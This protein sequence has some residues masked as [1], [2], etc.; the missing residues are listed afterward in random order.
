MVSELGMELFACQVAFVIVSLTGPLSGV[1]FGGWLVDKMGGYK[2]ESGHAMILTLRTCNMFGV[3]A[4]IAAIP[5]AFVLNYV[6]AMVS[7]WFVLFF[8]AALL[9]ALNGVMISCVPEEARSIAS[10]F[11]MF[12]YSIFGYALA[13]ILCGIIAQ[14][15]TLK[16]GWQVVLLVSFVA[17]IS[18]LGS[19][20]F[21]LREYNNN[22]HKELELT[23]GDDLEDGSEGDDRRSPSSSFDS[24]AKHSR[25]RSVSEITGNYNLEEDIDDFN[26]RR[27]RRRRSRTASGLLDAIGDVSSAASRARSSVSITNFNFFDRFARDVGPDGLQLPIKPTGSETARINNT[28]PNH[29]MSLLSVPIEEI[30]EGEDTEEEESNDD[31]NMETKEGEVSEGG[32]GAES[33][34]GVAG[35]EAG[36]ESGESNQE[37]SRESGSGEDASGSGEDASGGVQEDGSAETQA[38]DDNAEAGDS[39]STQNDG[40]FTAEIQGHEGIEPSGDNKAGE[41]GE[42]LASTANVEEGAV[43]KTSNAEEGDD[44]LA[45]AI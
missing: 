20:Y 24:P 43:S 19:Y 36:R 11:T 4:V 22:A 18:C 42:P 8:G 5:A 32:E 6:A 34:E 12:T 37:G 21:K 40:D 39:S 26:L 28:S 13:P 7:V 33:D 15:A 14:N 2:D 38:A 1:F 30:E 16:Q 10:S 41:L 17:L 35:D 25:F 45:D 29:S 31:D 27:R 3:G 23:I 9:P 44:L